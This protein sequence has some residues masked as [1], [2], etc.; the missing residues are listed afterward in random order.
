MAMQHAT[1]IVDANAPMTF[2]RIPISIPFGGC[3]ALAAV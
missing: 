3:N 1:Q 2:F